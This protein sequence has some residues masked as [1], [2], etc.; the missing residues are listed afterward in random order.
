MGAGLALLVG[1]RPPSAAAAPPL[2]ADKRVS[3]MIF[4]SVN[5]GTPGQDFVDAMR[6]ATLGDDYYPL[7]SGGGIGQSRPTPELDEARWGY[8]AAL[9]Y[10][11]S[12]EW[13]VRA[14]ARG[15]EDISALGVH[16][17]DLPYPYRVQ[18]ELQASSMRYAALVAYRPLGSVLRLGFGPSLTTAEVQARDDWGEFPSD[19]DTRLGF[20]AEGA[21]TWP[22][23]WRGFAEVAARYWYAGE[24][25][26][27]PYAL[28]N[29]KGT[30]QVYFPSQ[31]YSLDRTDVTFGAGVRF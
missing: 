18:L 12:P 13:E 30:V 22:L 7:G 28:P 29:S 20:L 14:L 26:Y 31:E 27:G 25:T 21:V 10:A 4:G 2:D 3:L 8:G 17:P 15:E 24:M 5:F 1:L 23:R 11:L 16:Q 6:A 19:S 9:G